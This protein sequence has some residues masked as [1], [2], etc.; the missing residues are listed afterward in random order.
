[1]S[2]YKMIK[3]IQIIVQYGHTDPYHSVIQKMVVALGDMLKKLW[4]D[5][6]AKLL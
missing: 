4:G 5:S 3:H 1:M 2:L 6:R